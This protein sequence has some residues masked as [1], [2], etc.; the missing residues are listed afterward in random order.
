MEKDI[1]KGVLQPPLNL[2]LPLVFGR[3]VGGEF[4]GGRE[5]NFCMYLAEAALSLNPFKLLCIMPAG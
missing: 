4:E 5:E 1:G 2:I 3:W